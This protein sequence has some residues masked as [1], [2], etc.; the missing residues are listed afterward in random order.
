MY[1]RKF[2]QLYPGRH[3]ETGQLTITLLFTAAALTWLCW[4]VIVHWDIE[5]RE[6]H[7]SIPCLWLILSYRNVDPV[8]LEVRDACSHSLLFM[9]MLLQTTTTLGEMFVLFHAIR[10]HIS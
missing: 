6:L 10:R 7:R 4:D 8:H 9:L 3:H 2:S 5:V 1:V